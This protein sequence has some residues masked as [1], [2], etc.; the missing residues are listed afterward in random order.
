MLPVPAKIPSI[1]HHLRNRVNHST[2]YTPSELL[3]G[4]PVRGPVERSYLLEPPEERSVDDYAERA[5]QRLDAA[6]TA[7]AERMQRKAAQYT[8]VQNAKAARPSRQYQVGDRVNVRW[9]AES[10]AVKK[11]AASLA[12]TWQPEVHVVEQ[13]LGP[14]VYYVRGEDTGQGTPIA[15]DRIK[16]ARRGAVV[17]DDAAE[18]P[19]AAPGDE[20]GELAPA[21][22][23]TAPPGP[24]PP[25]TA[26]TPAPVAAAPSA[27][28]SPAPSR[29][30]RRASRTTVPAAASAPRGAAAEPTDMD[31][32]GTAGGRPQQV[33]VRPH[34]GLDPRA[35]PFMGPV[36][37]SR[38]RA[39]APT[40]TLV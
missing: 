23:A 17:D 24:A 3:L 15:S 34:A 6:R 11:F 26:G 13:V 18:E 30:R 27:A 33:P 38:A 21:G 8:A 25:L 2:G 39:Q 35:P 28:R 4:F 36:T 7:A 12:S 22:A 37:R 1:L 16:P 32:A 9:A 14:D 31:D 5:F 20:A 29:R 10:D 19:D 40:E